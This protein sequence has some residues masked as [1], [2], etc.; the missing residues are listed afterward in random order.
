MMQLYIEEI[1]LHVG[2]GAHAALLPDRADWHIIGE[3]KWPK[4]MTLILLPS[5]SP[6]LNPVETI[7]LYLR[8]NYLPSRVFETYDDII[9]ATCDAL[10]RLNRQAG[11]HNLNRKASVGTYR[12]IVRA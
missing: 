4:D 9:D 7:W 3:L 1:A 10:K 12:S 2:R 6:E 8:A 11:R 5:C